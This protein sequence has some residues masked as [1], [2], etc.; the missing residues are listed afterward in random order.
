YGTDD[1]Y[2]RSLAMHW[3]RP[4]APLLIAGM[5]LLCFAV[6]GARAVFSLPVALRANW[7]LQLTAIHSPRSYFAAVRKALFAV[8]VLPIWIA[9]TAAYFLIWPGQFAAQHML[10]LTIAAILLVHGALD[11]FRKIPFAC[12]YLPGKSNLHVSIGVYGLGL[13]A[14]V[15]FA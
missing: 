9:C 4:N 5:V 7:M 12:S 10:V 11:Q 8:A 2:A 3:N 13:I 14:I 1:P 15:S 6:A